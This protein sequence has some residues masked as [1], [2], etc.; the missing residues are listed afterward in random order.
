[1]VSWKKIGEDTAAVTAD[2][3][4]PSSN[5]AVYQAV[6]EGG[7]RCI[8]GEGVDAD[9]YEKT[10]EFS[11][12]NASS[13]ANPPSELR[14]ALPTARDAGFSRTGYK[15]IGWAVEEG[16]DDYVQP[17][18]DHELYPG[19]IKPYYAAWEA[20]SE[21]TLKVT[22]D[23][24]VHEDEDIAS[25]ISVQK[26]P[27]EATGTPALEYKVKGA[28]DSTYSDNVPTSAGEYTVRATLDESEDYALAEGT[29]DF[30]VLSSTL[31]VSIQY[32]PGDGTGDTV[33]KSVTAELSDGYS[34]GQVTLL[35]KADFKRSGYKLAGW[36]DGKKNYDLGGVYTFS[37]DED[38]TTA[39]LT[40]TAVWERVPE[41]EVSVEYSPNGGTGDKVNKTETV[42]LSDDYKTGKITL[43]DKADFEKSGY[44]LTGWSD[45]KKTYDL[46]SVYT[47]SVASDETSK[48]LAFD[49]VWSGKEKGSVEI[50]LKK[51]TCY[52]GTKIEYEIEKNSDGDVT[53]E[54]KKT[55]EG[56]SK[57]STDAPKEPGKYTVRATLKETDDH[58][59]DE[60]KADLEIVYLDTPKD[61]YT[62]QVEKDS[63]GNV[64]DVKVKPKDGFEISL[65]QSG[66]GSIVSYSDARA[67]GI[68]L[69]RESDSAITDKITVDPYYIEDKPELKVDGAVDGKVLYGT[70]Y[71]V[72]YSSA[73]PAAKKVLYKDQNA[74]VESAY[75]ETAPTKPGNYTVKLSA[76]AA[77]FYAPVSITKDF[78][79][80]YLDAVP[81]AVSLEGDGKD[82]WFRSDVT[83]NAPQGYLISTT[84]TIGSFEESITWN[85]NI[86]ALY[87][88]RESDGAITDAI[89]FNQKVNIDKVIPVAELPEGLKV[90][91]PTKTITIFMDELTFT[92]KDDNLKEVKVEGVAQTIT[93][94]KCVIKLVGTDELKEYHVTATDL[95]GNVY[96]FTLYLASKWVESRTVP[97]GKTVS[98]KPNTDYSFE[99]GNGYVIEGD[100]KDNIVYSG[101]NKSYVKNNM[102]CS[103]KKEEKAK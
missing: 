49:A 101:G 72:S 100:K 77:G 20:K 71:N 95:A 94:K 45:G 5:I 34:K 47:F 67:G 14:I 64:T 56:D 25:K 97:V 66:F 68:Y 59:A 43:L 70:K 8:P 19:E 61:P 10:K 21:V 84:D 13:L 35:D 75:S 48:S 46:G 98:L 1:M 57:Y 55:G 44:T 7:Y 42:K 90:V 24:P 54:Y 51:S 15:L 11:L 85:E 33:K 82:G 38:D 83:I 32:K 92:I 79:I 41:V 73:S 17:E 86:K 40:F 52:L 62:Y 23:S 50:K 89:E 31:D 53:V 99:D 3:P 81:G 30:E 28:D 36:S 88:Q 74:K 2:Y 26:T 87:Y 93:N 102:T 96:S 39:N 80:V 78:S 65:T 76:D 91:D 16:T 6:Y 18:S 12:A 69:Q 29:A 4:T 58:T 60:D 103:F 37:V 22:V 27:A 9:V 63:A